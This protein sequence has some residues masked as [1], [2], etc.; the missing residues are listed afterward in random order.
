MLEVDGAENV[1]AI[2]FAAGPEA[3]PG[4]IRCEFPK[5]FPIAELKARAAKQ[6]TSVEFQA[7][8]EHIVQ[9]VDTAKP[10]S[11]EEL[12]AEYGDSFASPRPPGKRRR[13]RASLAQHE[14]RDGL[15]R[16]PGAPTGAA[17]SFQT[18]S[19]SQKP[20]DD[21]GDGLDLR[22]AFFPQT[23]LGNSERFR[24]R[25]RGAVLWCSAL[26]WLRWDQRSWSGVDAAQEVQML[27]H[28]TAR[29]IRDEATALRSSGRDVEIETPKGPKM[30]SD[31]LTDWSRTSEA[32]AKL[33]K[34]A[35]HAA[36]YLKVLPEQLDADPFKMTAANGTLV[37]RKTDDGPYVTLKPH[38]PADLITKLSPV[39]FDPQA[40]CPV[41]DDFLAYVQP[42][43]EM[44]RF[45]LQWQGLCLT[46]DVSEQRLVLFVG[47][48]GKNG[49]ST[50]IRICSHIGGDYSRTIPIETFL[51]EGRG[52]SAG[53]ATPDL[54]MLP[55]VRHLWASE[56]E[57][58]AKLAES[59]I[60]LVTGGEPI[61]ARHLWARDYFEF[62]PQ[63][64]LTI[65]GNY[66]PK[67]GGTDGGIWRR[68]TKVPW[69]VTVPEEK[70]DAQLGEKLR[71]ESSGILN[72]LL[73][74]LRDW[75]DHGLVLPSAITE[76]TAALRRDSDPC[77]RFLEY[78]VAPDSGARVRSS[79]MHELFCAW[80]KVSAVP[81]W[82]S[83]GLALALK[84]H[85]LTSK[86]SNGMWW[87]GVRLT[88]QISDF[89]DTD[90]RPLKGEMRVAEDVEFN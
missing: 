38:D 72:R 19:F 7:A 44:R 46:G 78:C 9:L 69:D 84:E 90:G 68:V 85:G 35:K 41:F 62:Y 34:I 21:G 51:N 29:S 76:A 8:C 23:D 43:P 55:G 87:L 50:F 32:A 15:D 59:L 71:A 54:A 75:L 26:E 79:E 6:D 36:P 83:K 12:K 17:A 77:G 28:R 67:I 45:L 82:T 58:G 81:E 70:R 60:K 42:S 89:V 56:P 73:D 48:E 57:K 25:N 27:A 33:E 5:P 14:A 74:G 1:V 13:A 22:L 31:K 16:T 64:K 65:S 18:N 39:V 24:E 52:R 11:I 53:Q 66:D 40:T 37:F 49:K 20:D 61:S 2:V 3:A 4:E 30:M 86:H 63:F 80:A 10:I 47:R 88:R